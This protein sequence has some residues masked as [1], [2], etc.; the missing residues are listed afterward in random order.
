MRS[1]GVGSS[2]HIIIW[3]ISHTHIS[4]SRATDER[5]LQMHKMPAT[6]EKCLFLQ[7]SHKKNFKKSALQ[8]PSSRNDVRNMYV[9]TRSDGECEK[10]T[11]THIIIYIP[12]WRA[13]ETKSYLNFDGSWRN[14]LFFRLFLSFSRRSLALLWICSGCLCFSFSGDVIMAVMP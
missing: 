13:G 9:R 4:W 1:M 3:M 8:L 7:K 5:H 10:N 6:T 14:E 12:K 2:I 11:H